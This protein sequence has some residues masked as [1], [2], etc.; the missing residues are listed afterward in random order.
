[1]QLGADVRWSASHLCALLPIGGCM[2]GSISPM[3]L[4]LVSVVAS[5]GAV[6]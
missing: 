5:S 2:M 3:I 6:A 1:M 4:L